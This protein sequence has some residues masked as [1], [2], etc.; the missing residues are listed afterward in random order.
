MLGWQASWPIRMRIDFLIE[1]DVAIVQLEGKFASGSDAEFIRA[2][3]RL[4][5]SGKS[6]VL[7]DWSQTPYLDSTAL[8]FLVG[9]YTAAKNAGGKFALCGINERMRE[10]LRITHLNDF[11]P[12]HRSR[13]IALAALATQSDGASER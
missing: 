2:K 10:V 9:L 7:T 12:V 11:M 6:K 8:N 5:E 4:A 3:E 13:E 1:G